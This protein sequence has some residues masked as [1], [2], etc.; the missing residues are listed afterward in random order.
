MKVHEEGNRVNVV[1]MRHDDRPVLRVILPGQVGTVEIEVGLT[2][3]DGTPCIRVDVESDA[4]RF[5]PASDGRIYTV[6]NGD[7]GP[8]VVFLTGQ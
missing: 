5:G 6:E 7:P 3:N 8:G 1:N 4:I 2:R